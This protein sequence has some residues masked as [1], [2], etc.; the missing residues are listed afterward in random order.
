ML[1]EN[2]RSGAGCSNPPGA[3][4][5]VE[6]PRGARGQECGLSGFPSRR[7]PVPLPSPQPLLYC[8]LDEFGLPSCLLAPGVA[9]R[10]AMSAPRDGRYGTEGLALV[11]GS[12]LGPRFGPP[13]H[14]PPGHPSDDGRCVTDTSLAAR[15]VRDVRRDGEGTHLRPEVP[16]DAGLIASRSAPAAAGLPPRLGGAR[17]YRCLSSLHRPALPSPRSSRGKRHAALGG[18]S[19]RKIGTAGMR[20][21]G[22]GASA[23]RPG[24]MHTS[25]LHPRTGGLGPP[26]ARTLSFRAFLE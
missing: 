5:K 25:H 11:P 2:T 12:F 22:P 21:V 6:M 23:R 15:G 18:C 7:L 3:G 24:G 8:L 20:T 19:C 17:T 13:A 4:K 9:R 1:A 16:G 10:R 14:K 26:W